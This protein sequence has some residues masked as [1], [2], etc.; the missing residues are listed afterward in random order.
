M[1]K[2]RQLIEVEFSATATSRGCWARQFL[3]WLE[4]RSR[5]AGGFEVEQMTLTLS[6]DDLLGPPAVDP[7]LQGAQFLERGLMCRLQLFVR[8][9]CLVEYATQFFS[10]LAKLPTRAGGI[11]PRSFGSAMVVIHNDHVLA[12]LSA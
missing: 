12:T 1:P 8:G 2:V 6:L 7:A 10:S 11:H 3:S 4:R 5:C 9:G